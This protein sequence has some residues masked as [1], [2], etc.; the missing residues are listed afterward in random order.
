MKTFFSTKKYG[1]DEGLSCVFRQPNATHSHCSLL[2]G[3]ALSFQFTFEAFELDDRNW[4]VDF[5]GLKELKQWLKMYFDH[6][7]CVDINDPEKEVFLDLH[8]KGL[9]DIVLLDG[10]GCEMFAQ[11]ALDK[12]NEI[13]SDLTYGRCV[14]IECEV[15]EH[16]ANSAVATL[17]IEAVER[18]REQY[19]N[20]NNN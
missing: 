2:H 19:R 12:A 20:R 7:C 13:V 4:V 8:G 14:C 10:V 1:H 3:Y 11:H 9:I 17:D 18:A 5:G 15:A 16:G 6:T